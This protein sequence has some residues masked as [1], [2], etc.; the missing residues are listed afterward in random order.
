MSYAVPE[1]A[2][3][4]KTTEERMRRRVEWLAHLILVAEPHIT[5]APPGLVTAIKKT[6]AVRPP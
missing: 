2:D 3:D 6:L 4:G 1:Y 5:G